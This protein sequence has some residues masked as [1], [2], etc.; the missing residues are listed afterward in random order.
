VHALLQRRDSN[1]FLPD[2]QANVETLAWFGALNGLSMALLKTLSPGVPD[3]YQGHETIELSLVDPDNRRPVDFER[4]R[5]LLEEMRAVAALADAPA[6]AA[7]LRALLVGA[8]DGRAKFWVTWRAL[9]LRRDA[10]AMLR[11]AEYLPLEVRGSAAEH[12]VAFARRGASRWLVVVATRLAALLQPRVGEAPLGEDWSDT[13]IVWPE[14]DTLGSAWLEDR[15]A[16]RRHAVRDGV[17]LLS[18]LLREWPVAALYGAPPADD[19][20]R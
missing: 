9:Q 1:L 6:R 16:M 2:L 17:L 13:A 8:V 20:D 10:E 15:I 19:A 12:V 4:R 5:V 14:H 3:F 18:E 7:A 11:D